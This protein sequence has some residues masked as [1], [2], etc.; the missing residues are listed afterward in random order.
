MLRPNFIITACF[1][2]FPFS[3]SAEEGKTRQYRPLEATQV[4]IRTA[5]RVDRAVQD[6]NSASMLRTKAW[7]HFDLR[8]WDK[9]FEAF[10][11]ALEKD[12]NSVPAAEG[13]AMSLY[14]SGDYASAFRLGQELKDSMPTVERIISETVLADV[15]YMVKQGE[16]DSANEFLANFPTE[17]AGIDLARQMVTDADTITTA[18]GPDG[19]SVPTPVTSKRLVH[20]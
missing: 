19:D 6:S 1:A 17:N 13:L 14:H 15:R 16:Y 2:C 4:A 20:N 18:L 12:P 10:L 7:Q 5:A 9:A 8:E 3:V 11:D